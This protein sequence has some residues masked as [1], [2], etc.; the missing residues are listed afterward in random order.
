MASKCF[1]FPGRV[2]MTQYA[3]ASK[4]LFC[5]PRMSW[6][7][8]LARCCRVLSSVLDGLPC[9]S[10][11]LF[12]YGRNET[13]QSRMEC[14]PQTAHK[15]ATDINRHSLFAGVVEILA[16]QEPPCLQDLFSLTEPHPIHRLSCGFRMFFPTQLRF[17]PV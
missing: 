10:C 1:P 16:I 9:L 12:W 7:S 2:L 17:P 13:N 3:W 4:I 5:E 14:K 8:I 11:G 6:S 15:H